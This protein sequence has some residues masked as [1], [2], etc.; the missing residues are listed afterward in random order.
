M[1]PVEF[2][3]ASEVKPEAGYVPT[4]IAPASL[5]TIE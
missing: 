5:A 4:S 2:P 3:L 1:Q